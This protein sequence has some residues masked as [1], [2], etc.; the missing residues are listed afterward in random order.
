MEQ[1]AHTGNA[2]SRERVAE[3]AGLDDV[4]SQ[5]LTAEQRGVTFEG[6]II[7]NALE[8][9]RGEMGF[10]W[11]CAERSGGSAGLDHEG[12]SGWVSTSRPAI[13]L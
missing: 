1:H 5:I 3:G 13:G 2:A 8:I 11:D 7:G 4:A 6:A 10:A 9:E 12:R